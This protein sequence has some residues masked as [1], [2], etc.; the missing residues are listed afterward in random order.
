MKRLSI[1]QKVLWLTMIPLLVL[2]ISLESFFLLNRYSDL[3][4]GLLERGKLIARQLAA[5]SEYGV[6]SNNQVFLQD[7]AQGVLHQPDVRSVAI[8][9]SAS[10]ILI[11]AD[12]SANKDLAILGQYGQASMEHAAIRAVDLLNPVRSNEQSVWIYQPII[13]VQIT[14]DASGSKSFNAPQV[15]AVILEMSRTR[16]QQSKVRVFWISMMATVSFL[17]LFCYLAYRAGRSIIQPIRKLSDAIEAI[18]RGDLDTRVMPQAHI[19]ELDTLAQGL[20]DMTAQLQKERIALQQRIED[21]TCA[22]RTKKED[23]ER[24]S[25]DKSHFLAVASHDLRQPL[26]ALGLYVAELQRKVKGAEQQHLVGRV[27]QSIEALSLLLNALLDIS[28]LDAGAIVPQLQTCSVSVMLE[29][30]ALDYQM[31]AEVK[32]IRLVV[33]SCAKARFIHSDPQLLERILMNLVGNAIRYTYPNGRVMIV[34]RRRVG[35]LRIEVRDNGVGISRADQE[36]IFREFFQA[37]KQ[38]ADTGKGLGLGLAIVDRLVKLLNYRIELRSSPGKGSVF[39]LEIPLTQRADQPSSSNQE[40]RVAPNHEAEKSI[41]TGKR[42]LV[43][44][45]DPMVLSSTASILTS[46]GCVVSTAESSAQAKQLMLG[47]E[48]WDFIIC[49]YQLGDKENG[50]DVIKAVRQHLGR[51]IPCI[52]ISGDTGSTLVKLASVSG[53]NL[54]HKPVRPAKLRSL[55]LFLLEGRSEEWV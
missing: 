35:S 18:G 34:C 19:I 9:N 33:R 30:I 16:I 53:H 2:A 55:I 21:A 4:E 49:D 22:L 20:N 43:I 25:H 31:L 7:I 44:D 50:M 12:E 14:L 26:H 54:L 48:A 28:K 27:E 45:D 51:N 3:D 1:H 41:L 24:A 6:F 13:P 17:A 10:E 40:T 42:L 11:H 46:W 15:G 32:N 29:R 23:A 47:G 39:A 8:L 38:Q 37:A 52:L 5:S 36:N